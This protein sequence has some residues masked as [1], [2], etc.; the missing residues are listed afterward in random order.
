MSIEIL[1]QIFNFEISFCF[2]SLILFSDRIP[3][4]IEFFTSCKTNLDFCKAVFKINF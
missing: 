2:S 3:L 1:I 4:V